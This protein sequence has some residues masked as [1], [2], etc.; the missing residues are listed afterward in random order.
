[1]NY[2][3]K[4]TN[5]SLLLPYD[6][7][8]LIYEYADP[9]NAVRKQ[10][11]N[12]DYDLDEIMYKRMKKHI[13]KSMFFSYCLFVEQTNET[14]YID[15]NNINNVDLKSI[16]LNAKCGYKDFFLYKS[17]RPAYICG[18]SSNNI[19]FIKVLMIWDLQTAN[20]YKSKNPNYDKYTTKNVYK[21][22]LKL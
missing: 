10:I 3:A 6:V 4:N 14:Y 13:I 8:K 1:M 20:I 19:E 15:N 18:L 9:L 22:W 11:E 5:N 21:K 2:L 12:K 17:K 16:I 7:M